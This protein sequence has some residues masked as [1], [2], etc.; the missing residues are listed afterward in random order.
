MRKWCSSLAL[1]IKEMQI[2][3]DRWGRNSW[4]FLLVHS[5]FFFCCSSGFGEYTQQCNNIATSGITL[6]WAD[7]T[8]RKF[9]HRGQYDK[10]LVTDLVKKWRRRGAGGG[11][12]NSESYITSVINSCQGI[13]STICSNKFHFFYNLLCKYPFGE[14]IFIVKAVDAGSDMPEC[15]TSQL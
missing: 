9:Q 3:H 2:N 15:Y 11:G 5:F 6:S 13:R 7:F 12:S 14:L 10:F 8:F 1:W 4:I